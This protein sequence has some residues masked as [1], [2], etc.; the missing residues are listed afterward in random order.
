MRDVRG[1]TKPCWAT[2]SQ[3]HDFTHKIM[4]EKKRTKA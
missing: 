3:P 4:I 1:K 2:L